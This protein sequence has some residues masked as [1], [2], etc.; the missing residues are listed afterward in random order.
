MWE[1]FGEDYWISF[2]IVEDG[3]VVVGIVFMGEKLNVVCVC[4]R[5]VD[6][7]CL[8]KILSW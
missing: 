1:G 4:C 7:L 2:C 8:G 5:N 3:V 6:L